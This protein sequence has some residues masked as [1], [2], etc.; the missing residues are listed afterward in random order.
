MLYQE[1]IKE[2]GLPDYKSGE[3][4]INYIT[5]LLLNGYKLNTRGCRFIGIGNLH[6]E[7]LKLEKRNLQITIEK[8]R[9]I[10]P[11][12]GEIPKQL[13]LVLWMT[14]SQIAEYHAQKERAQQKL[15]A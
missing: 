1:R 11:V 12:T 9:T 3:T 2:L 7:I 10:D 4:H 5:R 15:S 6:S 13:V 8:Q 14:P